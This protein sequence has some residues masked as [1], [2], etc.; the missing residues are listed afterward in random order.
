MLDL[1]LVKA[2]PECLERLYLLLPKVISNQD[3]LHR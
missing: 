2:E 3:V 1:N